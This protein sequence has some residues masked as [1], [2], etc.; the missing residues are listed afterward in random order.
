MRCRK[1]GVIM[2]ATCMQ[3]RLAV[4]LPECHNASSFGFIM[5]TTFTDSARIQNWDARPISA[6]GV[7][8]CQTGWP[9]QS[10]SPM[11]SAATEW[12]ICC[13]VGFASARHGLCSERTIY[14]RR[15]GWGIKYLIPKWRRLT[16][17]KHSH[18][19]CR[20][21]PYPVPCHLRDRQPYLRICV[22]IV[23]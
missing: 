20:D 17:A 3:L 8:R 9:S 10:Q 18:Y 2:C 13:Q 14:I 5:L 22:G 19:I 7:A 12:D 11:T 4:T 1:C 6:E 16:I 15:P 23:R 21:P